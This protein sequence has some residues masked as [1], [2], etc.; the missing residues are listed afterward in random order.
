MEAWRGTGRVKKGKCEAGG[1]QKKVRHG[2][3]AGRR[4][5][6]DVRYRKASL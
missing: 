3:L 1:E 6:T 4:T 5:E 2:N